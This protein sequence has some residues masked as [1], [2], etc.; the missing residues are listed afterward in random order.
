M[1]IQE[2]VAKSFACRSA[3]MAGDKLTLEE[4]NSLIDQL[5]SSKNPYFCPHGRPVMLTF[6]L[7]EFDK[8][9]DRT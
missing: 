7:E 1:D 6:S 5:F 9:F 3:I 4:M 8:R 2:R